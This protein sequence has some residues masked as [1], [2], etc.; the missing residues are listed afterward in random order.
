[1]GLKRLTITFSSLVHL[2]GVATLVRP[3]TTIRSGRLP[4]S[5]NDVARQHLPVERV[6]PLAFSLANQGLSTLADT[7]FDVPQT[8][9]QPVVLRQRR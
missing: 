9:D 8:A 4:D 2:T 6:S 1:M 5:D 7:H 3:T